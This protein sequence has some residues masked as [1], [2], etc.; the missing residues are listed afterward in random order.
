MLLLLLAVGIFRVSRMLAQEEGPFGVFH[1]MRER[2]GQAG[3]FGRGLH[4]ALCWS[5]WL[6]GVAAVLLVLTGVIDWRDLWYVWPG[7]S[8]CA[9]VIY[10][11]VR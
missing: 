8:G 4:C 5:W 11:V 2:A 1:A 6:A 9:V 7:L 10:Q 3:W